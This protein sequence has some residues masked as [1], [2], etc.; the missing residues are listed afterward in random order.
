[1]L[2]IVQGNHIYSAN[3]TTVSIMCGLMTTNISGPLDP[4]LSLL[5]KPQ[6][7]THPGRTC[8]DNSYSH[9]L[10]GLTNATWGSSMDRQW[11]YQTCNEFGFFQSAGSIESPFH[12]LAAVLNVS[13][14]LQLCNDAFHPYQAGEGKD[15]STAAAPDV[16][17]PVDFTNSYYGARKLGASRV[18]LPDGS[19]DP[20]HSLA[21]TQPSTDQLSLGLTPVIIDGTTHCGDMYY[22]KA[23]DIQ[24]LKEAHALIEA[25]VGSWLP[26]RP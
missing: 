11:T 7:K 21:L 12:P 22:P 14:Y 25:T 16:S 13:Y 1:V 20:W 4:L 9:A 6:N 26:P 3:M 15:E 2:Q 8:R 5:S 24:S 23:S 10:A 18:I 19:V 17:V